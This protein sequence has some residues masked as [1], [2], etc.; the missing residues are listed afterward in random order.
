VSS[1]QRN[2]N[3][4]RDA[5]ASM[6]FR[7]CRELVLERCMTKRAGSDRMARRTRPFRRGHCRTAVGSRMCTTPAIPV[8]GCG[9]SRSETGIGRFRHESHSLIGRGIGPKMHSSVGSVCAE[10]TSQ[11]NWH[12]PSSTAPIAPIGIGIRPINCT[13]WVRV[14]LGALLGPVRG[15]PDRPGRW[16]FP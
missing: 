1:C 9:H 7:S 8:G 16:R 15:V 5:L 12:A 2:R 11:R 6:D 4:T 13:V 14:A 10:G 3:A